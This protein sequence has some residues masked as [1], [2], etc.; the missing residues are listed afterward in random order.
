[1]V[2]NNIF[3]RKGGV[4]LN[5]KVGRRGLANSPLAVLLLAL[6]VSSLLVITPNQ[7]SAQV[8]VGRRFHPETVH[9]EATAISATQIQL[10][11]QINNAAL[12]Y[13]GIRIYRAKPAT[14]TVFEFLTTLGVTSVTFT[15][16]ELKS[17]ATYNYQIRY[18]GKKPI[19]LSVPSNVASAK[20]MDPNAEGGAPTTV[21]V[22]RYT[23]QDP[24]V[25]SAVKTL[26]ARAIASNKI[27]LRWGIPYMAKVASLRIFRTEPDNPNDFIFL[28]AVAA[29]KTSWVDETVYPKKTY[30]YIL[31]YNVG[32]GAVLSPPSNIAT[33]TTPD[34]E[35]P[36]KTP[37][38]PRANKLPTGNLAVQNNIQGKPV[39]LNPNFSSFNPYILTSAVPL[40]ELE[41]QFFDI[42]NNYRASV[43]VGPIRPSI[44]LCR[45]ADDY[46]KQIAQTQELPRLLSQSGDTRRRARNWGYN[47]DTVYDTLA[48]TTRAR[49]E[50][51]LDFLKNYSQWNDILINPIWKTV[52][53]GRAYHEGSGTWY[54]ILDFSAFWDYTIPLP[55]EDEEGRIDGNELVRTRPPSD[56]LA[57]GHV[58]TGYGDDGKPYTTLH[59]D[60]E[61]K[62]CWKDPA[63]AGNAGLDDGSDPDELIGT[64]H[65]QFE[66]TPSGIVHFNDVN[67][68]DLTEFTM[69]LQIKKDGTW[70]SQGYRAYQNPTPVEAGTWKSVHDISHNEEIITFYRD[71]GKPTATI[72]AHATKGRLTF[73]VTDGGA[74][75]QNFFKSKP[76]DVNN[77]DDQQ[78]IFTPG[79]GFILAPH[80]PFPANLRCVSCPRQ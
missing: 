80:Q 71:N 50:T 69:N 32:H 19:M 53:I 73:F 12:D 18:Q 42:V 36:T 4:Y 24:G 16:S 47:V 37:K 79:L 48:F 54:W 66:I 8:G 58:F 34:G 44:I 64:W 60:L 13:L 14:P 51:Y 78:V 3:P 5:L 33:T 9:L 72:R 38:Y 70:V 46:A 61:T 77:K 6:L 52:G 31:R 55:G 75:M 29:N 39:V 68:Y 76:A 40:D 20:T 74:E 41:Q 23:T 21:N 17:N 1:M 22:P 67:G 63:P 25:R 35:G 26:S 57:Q 45:S 28:D 11:W 10:V 27:E 7:A 30:S 15:D 49:P 56:A 43:G 2:L 59:C 62:A 65:L